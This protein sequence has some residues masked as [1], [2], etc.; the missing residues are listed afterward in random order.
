MSH[1][2]LRLL[3]LL[4]ALMALLAFAAAPSAIAKRG[5]A[6]AKKHHAHKGDRNRD[7]IPDRWERK[8]HLSLR[9]NQAKR[10][11]DHDGL[12]N[13]AEFQART[14]PRD[15][16]SDDDGIRDGQEHAGKVVSFDS[17]TGALVLELFDGSQ[18]S[19]TVTGDTELECHTASQLDQRAPTAA[20]AA[21]TAEDGPG[22]GDDDPSGDDHGDDQGD[23]DQGDDDQGDDHGD[24]DHGDDDGSCDTSALV[25][26]T[27]VHEAELSATDAGAIWRE[28]QLIVTPPTP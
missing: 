1:H 19:G 11:Q 21:R 23:D 27:T 18:M 4:T 26:G 3:T 2:R 28:V 20:R 9:V 13:R 5:A 22:S 8:H 14:D 24:D 16:D 15:G 7:R 12:K 6:H 17:A 25:P 10:D